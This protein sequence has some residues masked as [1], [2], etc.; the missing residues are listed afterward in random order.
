[1]AIPIRLDFIFRLRTGLTPSPTNDC[2]KAALAPPS[3][4]IKGKKPWPSKSTIFSCSS[5]SAGSLRR[6]SLACR[7]SRFSRS[8]A[9]SLAAKSVGTPARRPLSTSA[10]FTHSLS[11][12]AVQPILAAIDMI[13][14]NRDECSPSWSR[15]IRTAR[16]RTSGENLLLVCFVMAPPSQELE[17]PLNPGRFTYQQR[18]RNHETKCS[19]GLEVDHQFVLDRLH[20][21]QVARL[22]AL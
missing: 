10:F 9:F 1:M 18:L 5:A 7:S 11:V 22:D 2:K 6:I 20:N 14:A 12:C 21:G 4:T 19:G 17:P 16:A 8:S 15:I 3:A 13:A